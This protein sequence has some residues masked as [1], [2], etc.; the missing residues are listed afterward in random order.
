EVLDGDVGVLDGVVQQRT[1]DRDVVHA[2]LGD[3]HGDTQ[4]VRHVRLT[5]APDL[6]DVR[7]PGDVVRRLDE[8]RVGAAVALLEL[9][10]QRSN[11]VVDVVATPGAREDRPALGAEV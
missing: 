8:A 7:L 1:G 10:E 2:E 6:V 5:G 3:D 11:G 9:R 4:R